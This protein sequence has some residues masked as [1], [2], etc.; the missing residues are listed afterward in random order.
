[1]EDRPT[2]PLD[3]AD[4]AHWEAV[5]EASELLHE[6]RFTEAL[7]ALRAVVLR[8]KTNPYAFYF[9]GVALFEVSEL[10][11]AR[12]AYRAC[13]RLAPAHLGARVALCHVLRMQ[14][15]LREALREGMEA[16][17]QAPGDSDALHSVG[18]T[19]L[20]RGEKLAA[21]K[22]LEAFLDA[23]PEFEAASEV[24]ATLELL[25]EEMG[26]TN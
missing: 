13:L 19:Y 9:L 14:G 20:A 11:A 4:V 12:E 18:L 3:P 26:P 15:D 25:A 24:R 5:E 6:E 23:R 22:Y 8:D 2:K 1:M 10:D 17:S 21:R 16:L 7:V